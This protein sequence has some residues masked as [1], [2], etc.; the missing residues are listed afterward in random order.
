MPK[1]KSRGFHL[2]SQ[3]FFPLSCGTFQLARRK[4]FQSIQIYFDKVFFSLASKY[5]FHYLFLAR[6]LASCNTSVIDLLDSPLSSPLINSVLSQI[7]CSSCSLCLRIKSLINSL[8][9]A[10]SLPWIFSFIQRSF[11]SFTVIVCLAIICVDW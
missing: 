5:I 6:F 7:H 3:K 8:L 9:L 10:Y 2:S 11:G 4:N 1:E